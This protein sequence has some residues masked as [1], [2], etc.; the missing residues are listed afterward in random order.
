M[1][2]IIWS[3]FM[4]FGQTLLSLTTNATFT[5]GI[6]LNEAN[7]T[8]CKGIH[9]YINNTSGQR[10]GFSFYYGNAYL[11]SCTFEEYS[12]ADFYLYYYPKRMWNC[13]FNMAVFRYAANMDLFNCTFWQIGNN[14]CFQNTYGGNSM[15]RI[16]AYSCSAIMK[17]DGQG[18]P[19]ISN[20]Y[21]RNNSCI[22]LWNNNQVGAAAYLINPDVDNYIFSWTANYSRVYIQ[23]QFAL[24]TE[25]SAL[26]T[27][28]DNA[29]NTVFSVTADA[30]TGAIAMQ[31]IT[32]GFYDTT[33]SNILQ[34]CGP[35]TLTVTK[36][37]KMP[38]VATGFILDRK[39]DLKIA[40]RDQLSGTAIAS[41][42]LAGATFYKDDADTKLT[43]THENPSVL[44]DIGSGK[45]VLNLNRKKLDNQLVL[46]L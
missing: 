26:V 33:H 16:Y 12:N 20:L 42:V 22:V 28:K 14:G 3:N 44:I 21:A 27:L 46:G 45:P 36:A 40:L 8:T 17:T 13:T 29:G 35:F 18:P 39:T 6:L 25:T 19:S 38:Y 15:D 1:K 41:D 23:Y 10:V 31:T 34:D 5:A 4:A 7:K 9:F 2:H 24:I 30:T 32:R 43:G 37:R 11:Y